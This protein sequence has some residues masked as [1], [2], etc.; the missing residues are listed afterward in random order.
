MDSSCRA[1]PPT[2]QSSPLAPTV[3]SACLAR[4]TPSLLSLTRAEAGPRCSHSTPCLSFGEGIDQVTAA[5]AKVHYGPSVLPSR[6]QDPWSPRVPAP[7]RGLAQRGSVSCWSLW[8]PHCVPW[9]LTPPLG[10]SNLQGGGDK[11]AGTWPLVPGLG[12]RKLL[13]PLGG[14]SPL[15]PPRALGVG[16]APGQ[17]ITEAAPR[18]SP[19][20]TALLASAAA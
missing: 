4:G 1:C 12:F 14:A 11:V 9:E 16:R 10:S 3:S 2:P 20:Y 17:E 7:S 13:G 15:S 8:D 19:N 18:L 6:W 5:L